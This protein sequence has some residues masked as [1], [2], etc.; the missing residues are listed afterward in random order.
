MYFEAV[1]LVLWY[2]TVLKSDGCGKKVLVQV[3]TMFEWVA[4]A[5]EIESQ[6]V[7]EQDP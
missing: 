7:P 2:Q 5:Q 6:S 4:V 3:C 1:N